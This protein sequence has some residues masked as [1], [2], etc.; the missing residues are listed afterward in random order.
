MY[1][2]VHHWCKHVSGCS[3]EIEYLSS[4]YNKFLINEVIETEL[5][6]V[7][8]NDDQFREY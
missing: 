6:E 7:S 5:N 1:T 3:I 4:S 8:V 2:A